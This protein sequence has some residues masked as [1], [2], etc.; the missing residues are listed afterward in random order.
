M[1][2]DLDPVAGPTAR[3]SNVTFREAGRKTVLM[4]ELEA[5][6]RRG[7]FGEFF[8]RDGIEQLATE[9]AQ[10]IARSVNDVM[11]NSRVVV[12]EGSDDYKVVIRLGQDGRGGAFQRK[13]DAEAIAAKD[14]RLTVVKREEGRGWFVEAEQ[15]LDVLDVGQRAEILQ[16]STLLGDII[17]RVFDK[18][19]VRLG[20][21]LGAKFM[22]AEAGRSIITTLVKPLE[23]KINALSTTKG[24][25]LLSSLRTS[26]MVTCRTTV[27]GPM[28]Q[29]SRPSIRL[30]MAL[31]LVKRQLM[32]TMQPLI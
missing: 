32:P 22:Q 7:T 26:E 2:K 18:Q 11:V 27:S 24:R 20:D 12:A 5:V 3:P 6:N 30:T 28:K 23:K 14:P 21:R 1:P 15:R 31:P 10:R 25:D 13:I 8:T 4:E 16:K 17:G 19:T 9:T 29:A